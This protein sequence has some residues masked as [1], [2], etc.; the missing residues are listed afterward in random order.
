MLDP[1]GH[2]AAVD[3]ATGEGIWTS[4]LVED[5]G[6]EPQYYGFASSPAV[7][8]D[9]L[10][11][12]VGGEAGSVAGLDVATGELRW[13]S[14]EDEAMAQSPILAD[15]GGRRQVLV[16]GSTKLAG[17]DPTDGAI[18]WE[19]EHEG[20]PGPMGNWTSSP[21]PLGGNRIF[22]KYEDPSSAV[23]ELSEVDGTLGAFRLNKSRG[24]TRSYSPAALSGENLYGFTARFL[25][26]VDPTSGDLL[27]RSRDV[28]D[29]FLISVGGHLAVLQKTGSLHFGTASPE[30]WNETA[31]IDLFDDLAW[32]P[33]SYADG[34]FY[35]RSLG[36][37]AR[38]DLV[39]SEA[40]LMAAAGGG[41]LPAPLAELATRIEWSSDPATEIDAFLAE[42]ELP[43]IDGGQVVFLWRG[44][45][46]DVAIGGDMIGMRREEPMNQLGDTDLW[47]WET[48]LDTHA[49]ISYLFFPDYKPMT[50]PSHD[51]IVT[52]T[53][54]GPDMNWRR[55]EAVQMSWFAMPD[56]PGAQAETAGSTEV[57]RLETIEIT[58]QPSAPEGTEA[59]EPVQVPAHVWL[60]PGYDEGSKRYPV[61]YVHSAE[62]RQAGGWPQT[63]DRVV[64]NTVEPL[65]A[66]FPEWPRVRGLRGTF[67]AQF[68]PAI[69]ERFRTR[70]DRDGRANV[71]M[72]WQ[73]MTAAMVSF[74]SPDVFGAVGVQSM[75][76]LTEQMKAVESAVGEHTG[77]S[78]PMRLYLEWGRWDLVSPHEDMNMRASSRWA[79]DLFRERGWE[80]M[81]GEVWDSTDFAS[82]ANRTDTLLEALFPA[83]GTESGLE[84]WQ[85][86]R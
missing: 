20:E 58:I 9:T 86:G 76:L 5:L 24:M 71:G 42:R 15:I 14:F 23:I 85:T 83:E 84:A 32:T 47:W 52:A 18:L 69:D 25:S 37:I 63:L 38:V 4:H 22:L 13:R 12:Q 6:S 3:L 51:R 27:W 80:P 33:P 62:A 77:A 16:L 43:L 65:I 55:D 45:A 31:R 34:S 10:V 28:G 68:V 41:D 70:A 82:W 57:G 8:G 56:W 73:G 36:E 81:G 53:V 59:P 19:F 54:L 64:G 2:L 66:V 46:D 7:A 72:G 48:E 11:V 75:Y 39:R 21:L 74:A 78:I 26:A 1:W 79:W 40:D 17:I 67:A 29:G 35:V 50:D 30:A 49:R 60:P 44:P 61:V